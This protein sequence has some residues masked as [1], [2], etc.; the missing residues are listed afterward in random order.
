MSWTNQNPY[1]VGDKIAQLVV[2]ELP[3]VI[4]EEVDELDASDRGEGGFGSTD[5]ELPKRIWKN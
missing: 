2:V 4:I 5:Q 3:Q 1:K